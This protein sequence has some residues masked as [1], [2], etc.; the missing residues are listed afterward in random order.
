M[1][2]KKGMIS[3][4]VAGIVMIIVGF[5]FTLIPTISEWYSKTFPQMATARGMG[6]M[7][8]SIIVLGLVMGMVYSLISRAIP[9]EGAR[10]GEI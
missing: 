10:K 5:P 8:A 4:V 7:L 3:G 9:G 1:E 2:W 6:A